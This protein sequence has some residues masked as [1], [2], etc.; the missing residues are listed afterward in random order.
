MRTASCSQAHFVVDPTV[1]DNGTTL[2]VS[3]S[4]AGLGN[5]DVTATVNAQGTGTVVCTNPA[6]N[7]ASGQTQDVNVSGST[8]I[9]DVKHGSVTFSVTT[10][11]PKAPANACPNPKCTA[12]IT[13]VQFSSATLIIAQSGQQVLTETFDL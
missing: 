3:G 9:T 13:D 12:A 2:T 7:I 1:V 8:V 11:A 10:I 4:V 5:G 6:G